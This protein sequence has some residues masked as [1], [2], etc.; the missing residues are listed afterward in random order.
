MRLVEQAQQSRSRAQALAD[1][2][3]F[4]LTI[5]ALAVGGR[6]AR[7]PGSS[8]GAPAGVRHRARRD[9]A[10]HRL[11]ARARA[12]GAARRSPSP[13]RSARERA[14]RARPARAR[15][16]A[17]PERGRVRQDGNAHA[18]RVSASSRCAR[19]AARRTR[20]APP[21]RRRRARLRAPGRA[22]DR[23]SAEEREVD[24]PAG[25]RLRGDPR[26]RRAGASSTGR[27]LAVG[28]PTCSRELGVEPDPALRAFAEDAAAHAARASVYLVEG[29]ACAS[30][31]SPSPTR[32]AR[33]RAR[34]CSGCTTRASR[35]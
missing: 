32:S 23:A 1:R 15:G 2:A 22:G 24:D 26:P 8:L 16:G 34:R 19:R 20:R 10:R 29:D 27:Q 33:S 30:P 18:R 25:E 17:Q 6:H 31:R 13:R 3:A 9:G 4:C 21:R 11:P 35:S 7:S 5:V 28:G 12:R 14:A